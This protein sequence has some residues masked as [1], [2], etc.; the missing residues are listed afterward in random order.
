VARQV[1][2]LERSVPGRDDVA[3][4][5]ASRR[6]DRPHRIRCRVVPLVRKRVDQHL[7]PLRDDRPI[8]QLDEL[9][10]QTP[11]PEARVDQQI[12]S[13]PADQEQVGSDQ[14]QRVRLG[15][16]QHAL[17]DLV[18]AEPTLGDAHRVSLST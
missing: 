14:R 7:R 5:D 2:D 1:Q 17:V 10:A 18:D 8:E 15:D 6:R 16:P 11:D 12:A 3:F 9:R 13:A 4:R